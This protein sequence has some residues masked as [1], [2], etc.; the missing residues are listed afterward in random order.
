CFSFDTFQSFED[1]GVGFCWSWIDEYRG[2]PCS[3]HNGDALIAVFLG[4]SDHLAHMG[5]ALCFLPIFWCSV[6]TQF[7]HCFKDAFK[8]ACCV[9]S[10]LNLPLP[11]QLMIRVSCGL[12]KQS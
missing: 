11:P 6:G 9:V 4:C 8:Q 10:L 3:A 5:L 2:M 1:F 7:A 12:G